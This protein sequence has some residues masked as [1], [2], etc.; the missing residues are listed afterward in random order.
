MLPPIISTTP[1]SPSVWTKVSTIAD[2]MPGQASG[3]STRQKVCQPLSPHTAA[4]SARFSGI[5]SKARC[6]GCT[7]KGMLNTSEAISRP[8]KLKVILMSKVSSIQAP[9]GEPAPSDTSR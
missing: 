5:A 3:S 6:T 7:M 4:A 8:A 9:N 2:R 1:N